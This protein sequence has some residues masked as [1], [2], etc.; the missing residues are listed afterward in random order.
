M[1]HLHFRKSGNGSHAVLF[2]HG[3]GQDHEAFSAYVDLMPT[4]FTFY[5]IDLPYHGA[6]EWPTEKVSSIRWIETLTQFLKSENIERF[7]LVGYSL[8]GRFVIATLTHLHHRVNRIV[9]IAPDGIYKSIWY[10]VA[11]SK[12]FNPLFHY[13]MNKES[14]FDRFLNAMEKLNVVSPSLIKFSKKELNHPENKRRVYHAWTS[15]KPLQVPVR[16]WLS[17][18]KK[19]NYPV[20]LIL[21]SKDTIIQFTPIQS[22]IGQPDCIQFHEIPFKHHHMIEAAKP[23][24]ISLLEET[25]P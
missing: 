16:L 19:L 21:G 8:G 9:L 1:Y 12:L 15:L 11:T 2:F 3:F 6:S 23:L 5:F 13:L 25:K 7:S 22:K 10:R 17:Q 14:S 4:R 20:T 18:A 24:I